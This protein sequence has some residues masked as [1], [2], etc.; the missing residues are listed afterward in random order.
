[1]F[2]GMVEG[3][4]TGANDTPYPTQAA[5][6]SRV[7]YLFQAT[8]LTAMGCSFADG[9]TG[10]CLQVLDD[11]PPMVF[12]NPQ[13][14]LKNTV[15]S[16]FVSFEMSGLQ[17]CMMPFASLHLN[18]GL[19]NLPF[20]S[21]FQWDGTSNLLVEIAFN[22][23]ASPGNNPRVLLDLGLPFSATRWSYGMGPIPPYGWLI[24][25][26]T[27]PTI[28]TENS[29]PVMGFIIGGST[30]SVPEA[31][32]APG[33]VLYDPSVDRITVVA[34]ALRSGDEE[35]IILDAMGRMVRKQRL[36]DTV[37]NVILQVNDLRAGAY[38]FQILNSASGARI[39]G[40]TMIQ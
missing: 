6:R 27:Y 34:T 1:V 9:I 21:P 35:V 25:D 16:S 10:L 22:S 3:M 11:D 19:L 31:S 30:T 33:S 26:S 7:Q 28:G 8:E 15:T 40:R 14:S 20:D 36:S 13:V 18:A 2:V 39:L 12:V 38:L 4:S 29:R 23:S 32:H 17:V 5:D 37:N 24:T